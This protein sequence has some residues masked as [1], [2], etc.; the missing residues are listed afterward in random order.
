MDITP[1]EVIS[2]SVPVVGFLLSIVK[3]GEADV[4]SFEN[5]PPSERIPEMTFCETM[6]ML[7]GTFLWKT[8]QIYSRIHFLRPTAE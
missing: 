2:V 7:H 1:S 8:R 5:A 4:A 6:L 3:P